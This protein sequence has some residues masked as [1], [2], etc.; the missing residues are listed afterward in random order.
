MIKRSHELDLLS[1]DE[2]KRMWINYGRRS[3]RTVEP[4]DDRLQP[5]QPR[6][7]RRSFELLIQERIKTKEQILLDLPYS[8]GDIE[9]LAGLPRGFLT[10]DVYE[11][12]VTPKLKPIAGPTEVEQ[13]VLLPFGRRNQG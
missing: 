5:E 9:E 10:G 12:P 6:L 1:D 4:L 3:W 13:G 8:I 11:M 7:L 2:A